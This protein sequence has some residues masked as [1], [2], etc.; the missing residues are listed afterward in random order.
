MAKQGFI[1]CSWVDMMKH[2]CST[3]EEEREQ[4]QLICDFGVSSYAISKF[5]ESKKTK[6]A[7]P[8]SLSKDAVLWRGLFSNY[9][10]LLTF[11]LFAQDGLKK[12]FICFFKEMY[13]IFWRASRRS[14]ERFLISMPG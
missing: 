8:F 3:F 14:R 2:K 4:M 10:S 9:P 1:L 7:N 6:R 13:S 12:S 11:L 5:L